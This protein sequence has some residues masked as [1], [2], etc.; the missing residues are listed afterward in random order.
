MGY[1][2]M[3]KAHITTKDGTKI[4]IEGTHQEV[5]AVVAKLEPKRTSEKQVVGATTVIKEKKQRATPI[6]LIA[7]LIDG[8]YFKKPKQLSAIKLALEE[9]GHYFPVTSLSPA[10]LRLIR[11]RQL[12]RIKDKKRWL[13]VN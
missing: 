7:E 8:N 3:A 6:N 13:Y 2:D 4:T 1:W 9:Q 10:L 5:A 11:K 12:R